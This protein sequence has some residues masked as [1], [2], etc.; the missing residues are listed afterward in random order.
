MHKKVVLVLINGDSFDSWYLKTDDIRLPGVQFLKADFLL[1]SCHR[2]HGSETHETT[3]FH[4]LS[5][6]RFFSDQ[7]L[8]KQWKWN[9]DGE[10]NSII[11]CGPT[12]SLN[13]WCGEVLRGHT[14]PIFD[15]KTVLPAKS[16][17]SSR[18]KPHKTIVPSVF[19][20]YTNKGI[21]VVI[22]LRNVHSCPYCL[23]TDRFLRIYNCHIAPW[24]LDSGGFKFL[25]KFQAKDPKKN[26][27][28]QSPWS[29]NILASVAN[30]TYTKSP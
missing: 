1:D 30:F 7:N 10:Q 29:Q 4:V 9:N 24:W 11:N 12:L 2:N 25:I 17:A 13:E 26:K 6:A 19:N 23:K 20:G 14:M 15:T 27:K 16:S 8:S 28:E 22:P 21:C 18:I 5:A 3:D